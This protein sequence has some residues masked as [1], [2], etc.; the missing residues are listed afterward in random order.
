MKW[1]LLIPKGEILI[2]ID[3]FGLPPIQTGSFLA[4][5]LFGSFFPSFRVPDLQGH[6]EALKNVF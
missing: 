2:H 1:R 5:F 3:V 4:V 6:F